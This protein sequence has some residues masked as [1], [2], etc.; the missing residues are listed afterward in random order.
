MKKA[1]ALIRFPWRQVLLRQGIPLVVIYGLL[2]PY[3]MRYLPFGGMTAAQQI[4][5][6]SQTVLA[7]VAI[8]PLFCFFLPVYQPGAREVLQALRHPVVPCIL[9]LTAIGQALCIPLYGWMLA[10]LPGYR[11]IVG[12]LV[13][14]SVCLGIGFACLLYLLR[15]P[16]ISIAAELIY[17]CLAIPL[18]DQPIP[19]LLRPGRM[20]DAFGMEYWIAHGLIQLVLLAFMIAYHRLYRASRFP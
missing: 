11:W 4:F 14:Q 9:E 18:A 12:V 5:R 3:A 16:I 19:L 15:S 13:F 1:F 10:V 20:I 6:I 8:W 17:I 7:C 2:F